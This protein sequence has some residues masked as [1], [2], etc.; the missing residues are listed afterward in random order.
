MKEEK[1][2]RLKSYS[3]VF[4]TDSDTTVVVSEFLE[5][6]RSSEIGIVGDITA[7]EFL[8]LA[9][10][11]DIIGHPGDDGPENESPKEEHKKDFHTYSVS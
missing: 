5:T 2:C 4:D 1:K 7:E 8:P 11:S 9:P 3:V 10:T 6:D